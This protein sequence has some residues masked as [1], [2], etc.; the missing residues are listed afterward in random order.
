LGNP[1]LQGQSVGED[2]HRIVDGEVSSSSSGGPSRLAGRGEEV[3]ALASR[4]AMASLHRHHPDASSPGDLSAAVPGLRAL[5]WQ[6]AGLARISATSAAAAQVTRTIGNLQ[7]AWTLQV[8]DPRDKPLL[9]KAQ[10]AF[11]KQE[12]GPV[13]PEESPQRA[14]LTPRADDAFRRGR[15][16]PR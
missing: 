8:D 7:Y 2:L 15:T 11:L 3:A 1:A 16:R 12:G 14:T 9:G 10:Q 13:L 6:G 4:G 5:G